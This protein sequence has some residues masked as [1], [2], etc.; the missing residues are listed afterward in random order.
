[1]VEMHYVQSS[2]VECVGYDPGLM[3]LHV[4]FLNS[5]PTYVY[6]NVP[7]QVFDGMIEAPSKGIYLNQCVKSVYHFE[8]R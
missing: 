3:E 1:M 7:Q 5:A 8:K 6:L 4:R 2:N